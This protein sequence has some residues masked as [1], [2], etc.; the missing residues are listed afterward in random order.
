M[1]KYV[2]LTGVVVAL[3]ELYKKIIITIDDS[4]GSTIE[5][6][7]M[8]PSKP[9]PLATE[10]VDENSI[11]QTETSGS[12]SHERISPD[13]PNLTGID[14]GSVVEVKGGIGVFR[15]C[16]QI[17]LKRIVVLGDT[18]A[19]V[20]CWNKVIKFKNDVLGSP[21]AV[22]PADIE[23]CRQEEDREAKLMLEEEAQMKKD[24]LR[25]LRKQKE[26]STVDRQ[27]ESVGI[28]EG[29]ERRKRR[30]RERSSD[31]ETSTKIRDHD[32]KRREHGRD[33]GSGMT[34]EGRVQ[35]PRGTRPKGSGEG[36]S[37][38]NRINYPSHAARLRLAGKFE[39]LGI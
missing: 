20:K 35:E 5:A 37:A 2:R 19:E 3:D 21:W 33:A 7:C 29:K 26:H 9:N 4:S 32:K 17:R 15:E 11:I 30:Y 24:A 10:A 6:I 31:V 8:A 16:K 18:N 25:K 13:G 38:Q 27:R 39:A 36:L 1:I 28:S 14:V 34:R 12:N 23:K 22:T